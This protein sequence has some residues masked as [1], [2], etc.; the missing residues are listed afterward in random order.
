MMVPQGSRQD[1]TARIYAFK[2]HRA[3]LPLLL[4][5]NWIIPITV[6]QFFPN[7][8]IEP[9]VRTAAKEMYGVADAQ[10]SWTDTSRYMGIFHGV[11]PASKALQCLDCHSPE[12]RMNWKAL[13]YEGD[14]LDTLLAPHSRK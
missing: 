7:G 1:P 5:K 3:E 6:E 4:G 14:P 10:F 13:G 2:L 9:A 12:G 11:Q 8:K